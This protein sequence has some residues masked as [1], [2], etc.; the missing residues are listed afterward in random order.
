MVETKYERWIF[1]SGKTTNSGPN[2][3]RW[4]RQGL[5]GASLL[6]WRKGGGMDREM[7]R[8]YLLSRKPA[9]RFVWC[10]PPGERG[11]LG[12]SAHQ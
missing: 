4:C 10:K 2:E 8:R 1:H 9:A 3:M 7:A 11:S 12:K 5:Y 6:G